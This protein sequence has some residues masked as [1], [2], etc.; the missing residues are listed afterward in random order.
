M[1][2]NLIQKGTD[3]AFTNLLRPEPASVNQTRIGINI[4]GPNRFN[5]KVIRC[6]TE[7]AY[8]GKKFNRFDFRQIHNF[9][10]LRM[11]SAR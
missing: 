9:D 1:L 2:G 5:A 3:V 4:I 8:A 7:S 10:D 11:L 6:Q